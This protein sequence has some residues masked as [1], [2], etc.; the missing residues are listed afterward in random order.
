MLSDIPKLDSSQSD[1]KS[2]RVPPRER[3]GQ[4]INDP[5]ILLPNGGVPAFLGADFFDSLLTLALQQEIG[6]EGHFEGSLHFTCIQN[7]LSV[8][9]HYEFL[10]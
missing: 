10:N 1:P 9:V 3:Q 7:F 6:P 4:E 2:A 5:S 8:F